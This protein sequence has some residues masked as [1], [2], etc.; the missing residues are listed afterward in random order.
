MR[1]NIRY[2]RIVLI[3]LISHCSMAQQRI[4]INGYVTDRESGEKLIGATVFIPSLRQ[5]VSTNQYGFYSIAVPDSSELQFTFVGYAPASRRVGAGQNPRLDVSL[6]PGN[7]LEEIVVRGE[8]EDFVRSPQ[9]STHTL[10]MDMVKTAPVLGGET[11]ILKTIQL[12]PGVSAGREGSAGLYVRGGSPDQNLILLDGVTVYNVYHLFGFLSVFN[13][14]A[15]N[16]VQLYK[17]G[18]PARYG[19]RLSSVLDISM[20]EGN[21]KKNQGALFISPVASRFTYE[22]PI[23]P[24]ISSFIISARRTWLDLLVS[25]AQR[26]DD[27]KL[28]YNF[29]DVNAKYNHKINQRNRVYASLYSGRD[30]FTD[31][32]RDGDSRNAFNFRWGNL[33][34][35]V[36]WNR[37]IS[38]RLF[39]NLAASYS[40]FSFLQRYEITEEG[41]RDYFL[42]SRSSIADATLQYDLDYQPNVR[43]S[44]KTGGKLSHKTFSPEVKQLASAALDTSFAPLSVRAINAELY[45]EDEVQLTE[46]LTVNAGVRGSLYQVEEKTY[47]N[48][49]PRLSLGYALNQTTAFKASYTQMAQYLHLLTNSSLGLPTDLW[50]SSTATTA[51]Q[52]ASQY[53][54]GFTKAIGEQA[55]VV[56]IEGYYKRLKGLIEYA[57]GASFLYQQGNNW[58]DKVV[59]GDGDAYGAELLIEKKTGPWT[60][61]LGY[62]LSWANRWFDAIDEG[63]KFPFTYDRRH[64]VSLL[65]SYQFPRSKRTLSTS[66]VYNTGNAVTLATG[67]YQG[68]VPGN[69]DFST[70]YDNG[71][72]NRSYVNQ[73]NNYR[74]PAYHRLDINYQTE[75]LNRRKHYR[76]WIFSLYNAYNRLNAYFLYESNGSLKKYTLFPIIPSIAYRLEF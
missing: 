75:K 70:F 34:S 60:G 68:Q 76:T 18:I 36:R 35:V 38:A 74:M 12:I 56:T 41:D 48:L 31:S 50:V 32:Y 22:A 24:D 69:W 51:P 64:D 46:K 19:E 57:D 49:Q 39:G 55:Y 71:F 23:K 2:L 10:S 1:L 65:V 40:T 13:P 4:T 67:R 28:T 21:L 5:G 59:V 44:I 20:K 72:G 52:R 17:G 9:M 53:A 58:E 30:G 42:R 3:L 73:R 33:T 37:I 11:D 45:V 14:D 29:Y 63:R 43:H 27:R 16:N 7:V 61:L 66:F 62:T 6:Q 47:L 25:L 54:L 26:G 15:I 8:P